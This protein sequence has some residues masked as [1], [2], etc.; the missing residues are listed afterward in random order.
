LEL[1]DQALVAEDHRWEVSW[2]TVRSAGAGLQVPVVVEVGVVL[3][4]QSQM[5][6]LGVA[7]ERT[8]HLDLEE[9]HKVQEAAHHDQAA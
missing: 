8:A 2:A 3:A 5:Q 7:V 9:A 6:D 1:E 4:E